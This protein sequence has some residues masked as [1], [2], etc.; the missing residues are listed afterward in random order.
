MWKSPF[1]NSNRVRTPTVLQMEAVECGAAALAII[2][3]HY[4]RWVPLEELRIEC[5]V[6][7]DGSKASNIVRAARGYGLV[8]KGIRAEVDYALKLK[9]P[10]IVF[11]KFNHFLVVEGIKGQ[12]IYLND[13]A[14]GPRT[15]DYDEFDKCFTGVVLEMV[16]NETFMKEGAKQSVLKRLLPMAHGAESAFILVML[17]SLMLVL[18]GLLMPTL[19]KS[20]IDKVLVS[21]MSE[22]IFPLVVGLVLAG[23]LNAALTWMQQ[24]Y[25][26]KIQVKL[27]IASASRFFWHTLLLPVTFYTQ[28]Y[29]GDIASRFHSVTRIAEILSGQLSTNIVN[30]FVIVFYGVVML[31]ISIPLTI[32]VVLLTALNGIA[33]KLVQRKRS[34]LNSRLTTQ[35]AKV[36]GV[37]MGGIQ[38]IETLKATGTESDF[39][40]TWGGYHANKINAYQELGAYSLTLDE[41]PVLMRKLSTALVLGGGGLLIMSGDLTVGGLVAFQALMGYF[42]AP[43]DSLVRLSRDLQEVDADLARLEDTLRYEKD[44]LFSG[45]SHPKAMQQSKLS[46]HIEI[47][48]LTFGYSPLSPPLIVDFDLSLKPGARIALVG[49]SGSGKSTLA[50]LIVGL[51]RPNS[52]SILFDGRAIDDIPR[53]VFTQSLGYVDQ[54]VYLF[55]GS[56]NDNL[57]LWDSSVQKKN[58]VTAAHD[59]NIHEVIAERPDGYESLS[60]EG[61]NNFSGGQRQRLEIARALARNPS[62]LILDEAT[63]A[64]DTA[65]EKLI[66]DHVRRRG[67][68]C[69]IVAHRLSTIRDCDEIIVLDKGLVV[70]RGR[71][72]QLLEKQGRYAELVNMT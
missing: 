6:S 52:G 29:V 31:T 71:H 16:P 12:K 7:R 22:W 51:Y 2:L 62:I 59:A 66:D 67:C 13:P 48:G 35:A 56:I 72:N 68:S 45:A 25:L 37:G 9:P 44:P 34:D 32:G 54:D 41:V 61:G 17:A 23:L 24:H 36:S 15:I 30:M 26:A 57:A 46:G 60:D 65:T 8:S 20:F 33:V 4:G 5:G 27:A 70:E 49:G 38:A 3:A 14:L 39:F 43:I 58:I 11:W 42:T 50:K 53:D 55:E 28:R 1:T 63:A 19:I 69:I 10:F 47:R 64:L 21:S 40:S 18:P